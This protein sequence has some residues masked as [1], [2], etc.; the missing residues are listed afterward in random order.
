MRSRRSIIALA[1]G[2]LASSAP[3]LHAQW[4]TS[5]TFFV[6]APTHGATEGALAIDQAGRLVGIYDQELLVGDNTYNW[7]ITARF[8]GEDGSE[9]AAP[10]VLNGPQTYCCPG[11][12]EVALSRRGLGVAAWE[13]P[14]E[15][16]VNA[17]PPYFRMLDAGTGE[18]DPAGSLPGVTSF[19]GPQMALD[20]RDDGSFVAAWRSWGSVGSDRKYRIAAGSYSAFGDAASDPFMVDDAART[21]QYSVF[22]V[23]SVAALPD[24]RLVVVW[25]DLEEEPNGDGI[26]G[27]IFES[28]GAP[29]TPE[30]Q[31]NS[32]RPGNQ[33]FPDVAA[34]AR[35]NFFVVWDSS[36]QDGFAEG[37]YG[38]RFDA[39][40]ARVGGELRLSSEALS[41]QLDPDVSMDAAGNAVVVWTSTSEPED[42]YWELMARAYAPDGAALGDPI[43]VT[44]DGPTNSSNGE[45][46]AAL[47]DAGVFAIGWVTFRHDP[48]QDKS[49][50]NIVA[51]QFA[52]PC[53]AD[54]TTLC[55]GSGRFRVRAF[56]RSEIGLA[57]AA[58]ALPLTDESGGFWFFDEGNF[59]LLVK[60]LDGCGVNGN[61]WIYAAGL[62]DV[63]VD[64]LVTDTWTGRVR[65]FS[66]P[67]GSAFQ[68]I[69]RIGDLATCGAVAP[70]A[71]T[72]RLPTPAPPRPLP[73]LST[74]ASTAACVPDATT[75]CLN[76]ARFRVTAHWQDFSGGQGSA[77][78]VPVGADS[79]LFWFFWEE[80]LEL[81][82]KVLDGCALN[83][84][85]WV[86]SA[87]LTNVAVTLRVE[88]TLS[89]GVWE[90][91][92]PAGHAYPPLLDS[93]ALAVCP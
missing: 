82:V 6:S 18:V 51:R 19:G 76:D 67:S 41:A 79:G 7:D 14:S 72:D 48:R 12:P 32:H 37:V 91:A 56:Y 52:L 86:Y 54:D 73:G 27:R 47:S 50:D 90:H 75:L 65:T 26:R 3:A 31:V 68:P 20:V 66:S 58:R 71:V 74:G 61:Y 69:Q 88:D 57:G 84:R 2:V 80:N 5:P 49:V 24:D 29:V 28:D 77:H 62:T 85:Y 39:T 33:L 17:S 21:T 70:E 81:A 89:G 44:N 38:Q 10:V 34:D 30:F 35:G 87:G 45:S 13:A 46:L 9:I 36:G 53:R 93:S 16:D 8:F 59:E 78:A 64:L 92:N 42:G 43:W 25:S 55:L 60:V 22:P 11:N 83:G 23:V 63:E 1:A 4:A 40:G 15:P